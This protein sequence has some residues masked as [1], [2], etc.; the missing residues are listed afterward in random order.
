ME[1]D[2]ESTIT[3][4]DEYMENFVNHGTRDVLSSSMLSVFK[5]ILSKFEERLVC[6][7]SVQVELEDQLLTSSKLFQ[8]LEVRFDDIPDL[9]DQVK[10]LINTKRRVSNTIVLATSI[11]K[12]LSQLKHRIENQEEVISCDEMK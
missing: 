11:Q 6:L 5:T 1:G 2:S 3:S 8:E 12:R 7:R 9:S 4:I 10:I